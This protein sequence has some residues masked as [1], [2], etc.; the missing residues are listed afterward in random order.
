MRQLDSSKLARSLYVAYFYT[1]KERTIE[2]NSRREILGA[3]LKSSY[4]FTILNCN[5]KI[6]ETTVIMTISRAN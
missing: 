5:T 6:Q 3:K 4:I 1:I 2:P